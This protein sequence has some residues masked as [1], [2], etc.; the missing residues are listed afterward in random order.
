[1]RHIVKHKFVTYRQGLREGIISKP[2]S[3]QARGGAQPVRISFSPAFPAS[4]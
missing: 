2:V 1:M 3:R 4:A